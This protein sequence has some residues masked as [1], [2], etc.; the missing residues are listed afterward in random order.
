MKIKYEFDLP[1]EKEAHEI[2]KQADH[3]HSVLHDFDQGILRPMRKYGVYPD[4]VKTLEE[5]A[6]HIDE[7]F[8]ELIK[9]YGVEL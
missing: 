4:N 3:M 6:D 7:K 1:E 9:K 2:F 5:M 8:W